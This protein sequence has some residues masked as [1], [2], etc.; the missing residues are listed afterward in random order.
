[1]DRN[2]VTN[3]V[4]CRVGSV[5]DQRESDKKRSLSKWRS[6]AYHFTRCCVCSAGDLN[7]LP[8]CPRYSD[9]RCLLSAK[10]CLP[11]LHPERK[12]L[13][14]KDKTK[15]D[16]V[17]SF[18]LLKQKHGKMTKKFESLKGILMIQKF[19]NLEPQGQTSDSL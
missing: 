10:I 18:P 17:L 11:F 7:S 3:T 13:A 19:T 12:L 9:H 6:L 16:D 5:F 2:V 14:S 1:M 15:D 8:F 4:N